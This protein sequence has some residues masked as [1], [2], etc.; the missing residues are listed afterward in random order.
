MGDCFAASSAA[1]P[2]FHRKYSCIGVTC[3]LGARLTAA[4]SFVSGAGAARC[5]SSSRAPTSSAFLS[6]SRFRSFRFFFFSSPLAAG[7]C[8][9]VEGDAGVSL[10]WCRATN[11]CKYQN[12]SL[13]AAEP[14]N[15]HTSSDRQ[16]I[17]HTHKAQSIPA[18]AE[19]HVQLQCQQ[20][21]N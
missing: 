8:T 4:T 13:E 6:L 10:C 15:H 1:L 17:K 11:A 16:A 14:R 2:A 3:C 7:V 12:E 18:L 19:T 20:R 9:G 21:H 5:C